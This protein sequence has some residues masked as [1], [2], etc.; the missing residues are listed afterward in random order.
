MSRKPSDRTTGED[1]AAAAGTVETHHAPRRSPRRWFRSRPW[2]RRRRRRR[3]LSVGGI[4]CGTVFNDTNDNG[5]QDAGETGDRERQVVARS[6][7]TTRDWPTDSERILRVR[8]SRRGTYDDC[9]CRYR[10]ACRPADANVGDQRHARQ[11]RHPRR[12]RAMCVAHVTL[13]ANS[14]SNSS[15][16]FGFY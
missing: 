6:G 4:V 8:R 2:R 11:R 10:R 16:D 14:V 1:A 13:A 7:D 3:R 15:T 12:T 9:R 5:I